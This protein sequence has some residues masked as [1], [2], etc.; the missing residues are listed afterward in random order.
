MLIFPAIDLYEGKAVRLFKGDYNEMTVYSTNPPEVAKKFKELGATC[1]HLVDLE[2]ARDGSTPNLL[3]VK[4]ICEQTDLFTEIGGGIRDMETVKT[5]LSA[6]ADRVILGTAAV[7]D[8]SFLKAAVNK[9]GEKIAVG[10]DIKDGKVAIRGWLEKSEYDA[11]DFCKK[12]EEIGVKTVICTDISR[13]GAMQG[14]NHALY[15]ELSGK[16]KINFVASGGV[17]SIEDVKK[18]REQNIYAAIVGKAYYTG[19]ISLPEA[20]EVAK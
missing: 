4:A 18:L 3:V 14:A 13:D 17:S 19:A 20:I 8:E 6:G 1:I 15:K 11:F 12:L 2:G 10:V 16:F 7:T 9:Y 5:Y